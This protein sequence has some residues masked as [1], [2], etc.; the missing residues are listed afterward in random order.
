MYCKTFWKT[1]YAWKRLFKG[2]K[3]SSLGREQLLWKAV[4]S[5]SLTRFLC[6][7]NSPEPYLL[8]R[9]SK[10]TPKI[11]QYD[12]LSAR[13]L[14]LMFSGEH[15]AICCSCGNFQRERNLSEQTLWESLIHVL[16]FTFV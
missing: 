13:L 8:Y 12:K 16:E 15:M 14:G 9:V 4:D 5:A 10:E 6:I 1:K 11:Y 7:H 2:K 3:W